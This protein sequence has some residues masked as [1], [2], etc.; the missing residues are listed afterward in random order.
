M[1]RAC[2]SAA[3]FLATATASACAAD[4]GAVLAR[5]DSAASAFQS[6]TANLTKAEYTAVIQD[7]T[8]ETGAMRMLRTK[9]SRAETY[10]LLDFTAPDPRQV[11]LSPR[12]AEVFYPK[13]ATVQEWDIR[14]YRNL[15]DQFLLLG[16][17]SSGRELSKA[18]TMK[19]AG[20]ETVGG[21]TADHL[22]LIP[23]S[24]E[25]LKHLTRV[26]L[27]MNAAGYPLRQRFHEPS[28]NHRTVTYSN[29]KI[30]PGLTSADVTLKL[31]G[32]VVREFPGR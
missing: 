11:A 21:E 2:H 20:T 19:H 24:Q 15:V 13:I 23:K 3:I 31:P 22:E 18:Y 14:K 12:K 9:A 10:L 27:W 8:T 30:N 28:G 1:I 16:F 17:G 25:T 29:L 4:L 5:M 32:N 26:E 7:T 6:V